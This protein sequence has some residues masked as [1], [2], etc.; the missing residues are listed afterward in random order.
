MGI[1]LKQALEQDKLDQFIAE[2]E[3]RPPA[4]QEAFNA[5]L[6]SMAGKSKSEPETSPLECDDD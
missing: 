4:D 6:N 1:T 5:T 2:R 3:D